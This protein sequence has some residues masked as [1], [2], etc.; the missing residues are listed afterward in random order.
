MDK[1]IIIEKDSAIADDIYRLMK[2][3]NFESEIVRTRKN[4]IKTLSSDNVKALFINIEML[5]INPQ[6]IIEHVST[7]TK[8][9]KLMDIS[10]FYIYS[11]PNSD[12]YKKLSNFPHDGEL[13]K[14]FRAEDVYKLFIKKITLEVQL[15]AENLFD[16][17]LKSYKNYLSV[18]ENWL[19]RFADL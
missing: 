10:I 4:A 15:E 9:K 3:L 17:K 12:V 1:V 16:D 13:I 7:L 5:M 18:R 11:D 8:N 6:R 14:P 2:A 19:S